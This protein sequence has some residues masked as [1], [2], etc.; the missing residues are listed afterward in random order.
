MILF[1]RTVDEQLKLSSI[2]GSYRSDVV[3]KFVALFDLVTDNLNTSEDS[4]VFYTVFI[5]DRMSSLF[6][7]DIK[8][9]VI[10][11]NSSKKLNE[12]PCE[13]FDAPPTTKILF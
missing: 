12:T 10:K 4:L 3:N 8:A 11:Q 1:S 2:I 7:G 5:R 6:K 9:E 13:I